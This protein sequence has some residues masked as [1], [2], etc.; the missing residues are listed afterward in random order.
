MERARRSKQTLAVLYVDL[1]GFT[2]VNE[3]HGREA[4]DRLLVEAANRLR[5]FTR[6]TDTVCRLAGDEFTLI[7]EEAGQLD[8]VER[9]CGRVV[10]GLSL[11]LIWATT[12]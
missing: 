10:D 9:I 7:L 5:A 8:E 2:G 3:R 12:P 4:G 6:T 11:P 1:D